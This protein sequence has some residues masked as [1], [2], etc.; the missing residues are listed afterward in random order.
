MLID[1]RGGRKPFPLS[2]ITAEAVAQ[3]LLSGWISHFG[4]P[5]TIVTDRGRQ[6]ESRLWNALMTLLGT[7]RAR[8]TAYHPQT[9]GVVERFHRQLEAALKTRPQPDLWTDVLPLVLLGIRT[10][11][12]EDISA[13]AAE[14]VYGTT[15]RLP[16]EFF[17]L[18]HFLCQTH[19]TMSPTSERTCGR[20]DLLHPVLLSGTATSLMAYRLPH[21]FLFGMMLSAN[22]FKHHMMD[23][24]QSSKEPIN[25]SP[26][27]S[28]I[29][30]TLSP[31]TASN[32]PIWIPIT[33]FSPRRLH[34]QPP[35]HVRP[36]ALVD[37][38]TS[39]P[40]YLS[41]THVS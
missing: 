32:Q 23:H 2:G 29:V 39:L 18:K 8:T 25:T 30:M 4:V 36:P 11:L 20:S 15:L 17:T 9:N 7:K 16:G 40:S 26:S 27:T 12:K 19:L 24:T 10:A 5:S 14:M 21:T 41:T 38:S 13:T 35:H 31:L 37:V 34:S 3:V 22:H 28:T 6:F 33:H 1:S